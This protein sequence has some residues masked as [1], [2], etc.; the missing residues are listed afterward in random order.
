MAEPRAILVLG[1][2]AEGLD[3]LSPTDR[4]RLQSAD[5]VCGGKRHLC[6]LDGADLETIP[7]VGPIENVLERV[8]VAI[9]GGRRL[10]VLASGDPCCFGIGSL[11][12]ERFGREQVEIVPSVSA[13]QLAFARLGQQWQEAQLVSAHG[14][15][16]E[17]VIGPVLAA[18]RS[19][20]LTDGL[21]TPSAIARMLS[22]CGLEDCPVAVA[23][24]LGGPR[25]R[26]VES[27][28]TSIVTETF[29]PL[30]VFLILRSNDASLLRPRL[31]LPDESY[32]HRGAMIT[33]AEVRAVS[34]SQLAIS[35][36]DVVWDIGAG[37]GSVS[38]EAASFVRHGFVYAVERDAQQLGHLRK[39]LRAMTGP[40]RIVEGEAPTALR[41]LPTPSA[42][43]LGGSGDKLEAI[44][45][46]VVDRLAPR[47]RLVAN[48][49]VLEHLVTC[50]Q[51]LHRH[52]WWT[53][54]TQIAVSRGT[55]LGR[56]EALN[57]VFVLAAGR[58]DA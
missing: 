55:A 15:P 9:S 11:L 2:G 8:S 45:D 52:G 27:T 22:E 47:G 10:A 58:T 37:C 18:R 41:V 57:P 32:A 36:G 53:R 48:F 43:F 42:V 33:K 40:A 31:G 35:P 54:V 13:I 51:H 44:L 26:I 24:R 7:I 38:L 4:E 20:I 25:E 16:I 46:C 12:V 6:M 5:V 23:E 29:D 1:V 39:N 21:N 50:Q 34:L 19:A 30:N 14:R 56:L 17:G 28:L 49:V 3:G